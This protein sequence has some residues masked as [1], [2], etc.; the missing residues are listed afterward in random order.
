MALRLRRGSDTD[1]QTETFAQG[2]LIYVT[3]TKQ[4][5]VGDGI[6]IGGVLVT[7]TSAGSPAT[8]TQNLDLN[9]YNIDGIGVISATSFVGDGSG[10]TGIPGT[11]T[12]TGIEL[13]QTY[14]IDIVGDVI[15]GNST[16]LVDSTT[17][18]FTGDLTGN[19]TG[20]V[21][22]DV[23]G[24]VTGN[25]TGN[26]TGNVTGDVVGNVTGNLTGNVTGGVTG[27]VVSVGTS[28]FSGIVNLAGS[29]VN[30]AAFNLTGNVTGAVIGNVTGNLTGGVTGNV[31]GDLVGNV[32]AVV[33]GTV[34]VDATAGK[35]TGD[36]LN[37]VVETEQFKLY[38]PAGLFA[39]SEFKKTDTGLT[40]ST[41]NTISRDQSIYT[42]ATG[43]GI[44]WTSIH[45]TDRTVSYVSELLSTN[46][47]SHSTTGLHIGS[48]S[49]AAQKLEVAGNAQITQG[50]LIL[51]NS[52][53]YTDIIT[54]VDGELMFDVINTSLY[55][56][57]DGLGSWSKV[58]SVDIGG[59]ILQT[60]AVVV[61]ISL[62]TATRDA[63]GEDSSTIDGGMLYNT[64]FD[65]VQFFQAGSWVNLPN[66][67]TATG[68]VL[69]WN[70]T[71]WA[72]A[73]DT[74]GTVPG[75]NADFLDGFDGIYYLDYD[76]F[77]N[78]PTIFDGVFSSLTGTP[79]TL[80]GYGITDAATSS[81]GALADSAVQPATLGNFTFTGS[82]LDSSDSS[83]ITVTPAVTVSSDLTVENNLT[84][85]NTVYA[86][87]FESTTTG[88]PTIEAAT[89]L[90]LTAGNAV[91]ITSSVLRL[92]SF[93]TTE[94]NTLA[95]QNGD[96]IYN[97][98]DNKF[99]GY[100]N[101][102]WANLI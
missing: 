40:F 97:T 16:I 70:G 90:D 32:V 73:Q 101:G 84:V 47:I 26:L 20:G 29:I 37:N 61:P 56:Y 15:G 25:L 35:I 75:S 52:R 74:G 64:D 12:G 87:R 59:G 57:S 45:Y 30:D 22:G 3:D 48:D 27:D 92:A 49:D 77:A 69:K 66:N 31:D 95:A 85:T 82:V 11:G 17:N 8:L 81:Q 79:T 4:L 53:T 9:G 18:T 78:T 68:E 88:T 44:A 89:N 46:A 60:N 98:T 54:P 43:D 93:T 39:S 71:E 50:S 83:G 14:L 21:T 34:L 19:V 2:E 28:A 58:L 91:R 80:G 7:S 23:V 1:R 102:A 33:G 96:V 13:G 63:V 72:A 36:V 76:N 99:Q 51:S 55:V 38:A 67:G 10:L 62:A 6:T 65:R 24:N 94:R 5:Y 41:T 100:E 42:D 86:E